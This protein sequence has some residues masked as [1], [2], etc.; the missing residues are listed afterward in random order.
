MEDMAAAHASK[1]RRE[2]V[3]NLSQELI[4]QSDCKT[5][6]VY[7]SWKIFFPL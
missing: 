7:A 2:V 4:E 3:L 1:K 5:N 6:H